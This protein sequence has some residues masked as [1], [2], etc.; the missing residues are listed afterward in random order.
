MMV[1]VGVNS[2][3]T[4]EKIGVPVTG[5]ACLILCAAYINIVNF[6]YK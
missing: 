1:E 6:F 3:M 5:C 4:K 2:G